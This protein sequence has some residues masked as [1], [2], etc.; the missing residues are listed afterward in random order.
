MS[1][2]QAEA[3]DRTAEHVGEFGFFF[4]FDGTLSPI[5]GDPA[6]APLAA[7]VR[8]AVARLAAVARRV[9]IVSARPVAFLRERFAGIPLTMSGMYGLELGTVDGHVITEPEAEP[10]I[11]VVGEV[12][13]AARSELAPR[14]ALVEPK[15]LSVALHYRGA[16]HLAGAVRDWATHQADATGLK[17]Q[18]GRMVVELRPPIEC[19]KGTALRPMLADLGGAWYVGDDVSDIRAFD[20]LAERERADHGFVAV[21][22]AVTNGEPVGPLADAADFTLAEPEDVGRLISTVATAG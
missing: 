8:G 18:A 6:T 7:G 11:P 22:A 4:D 1:I 10:W 5:Q 12:T 14:G 21:R 15:R 9:T 19:D 20:A 3:L 16:P 13:D 17:V 2:S